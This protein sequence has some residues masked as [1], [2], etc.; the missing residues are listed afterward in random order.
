[1][2]V[3]DG[4][5]SVPQGRCHKIQRNSAGEIPKSPSSAVPVCLTAYHFLVEMQYHMIIKLALVFFPSLG[6]VFWKDIVCVILIWSFLL[7]HKMPGTKPTLAT[8][9]DLYTY[10]KSLEVYK[11]EIVL[12]EIS[13]LHFSLVL[14]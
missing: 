1:M 5:I 3:C 7:I 4:S 12:N 14:A 13:V 10:M 11:T 6:M 2:F 9:K 8:E